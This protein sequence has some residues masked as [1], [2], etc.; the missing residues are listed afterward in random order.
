MWGFLKKLKI[1]LSYGSTIPLQGIHLNECQCTTEIFTHLH[2]LE[3]YILFQDQDIMTHR[4]IGVSFSHKEE[5]KKK[6]RIKLFVENGY[7]GTSPFKG[8]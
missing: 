8:K 2:L 6:N 3:C 7:N 4:H 5:Q 1:E